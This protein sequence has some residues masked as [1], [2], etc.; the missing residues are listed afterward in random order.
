L[1]K[2]FEA[3][4]QNI[5][6]LIKENYLFSNSHKF[7]S[8][9]YYINRLKGVRNLFNQM[10]LIKMSFLTKKFCDQKFMNSSKYTAALMTVEFQKLEDILKKL[11]SHLNEDK[12][13]LEAQKKNEDDLVELKEALNTLGENLKSEFL[14]HLENMIFANEMLLNKSKDSYMCTFLDLSQAHGQAFIN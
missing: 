5:V 11:I 9:I 1:N 6:N 10:K 2:K 13:I 7:E 12:L 4:T 3:I 14:L 8:F